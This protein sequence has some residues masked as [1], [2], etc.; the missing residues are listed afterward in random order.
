MH[1]V[2]FGKEVCEKTLFGSF[3]NDAKTISSTNQTLTLNRTNSDGKFACI[4]FK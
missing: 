4:V 3:I 2:A 1:L